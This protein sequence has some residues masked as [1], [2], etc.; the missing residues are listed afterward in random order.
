MCVSA[1][2]ISPAALTIASWMVAGVTAF[3][4]AFAGRPVF[5][6]HLNVY[7]LWGLCGEAGAID[8]R[9]RAVAEGEA[10]VAGVQT[11]GA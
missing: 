5:G 3:S 7:R 2:L 9:A 10:S 11:D 4:V 6:P 1:E 8:A